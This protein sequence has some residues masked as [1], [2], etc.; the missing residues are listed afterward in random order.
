[1]GCGVGCGVGTDAKMLG[2]KMATESTVSEAPRRGRPGPT[3]R[4]GER[5]PRGTPHTPTPHAHTHA[6]AE[7]RTAPGPHPTRGTPTRRPEGT[8]KAEA[9]R[10][11][12]RSRTQR[13]RTRN[14]ASRG[15]KPERDLKGTRNPEPNR[16]PS[17]PN[18]AKGRA[19]NPLQGQPQTSPKA[20]QEGP[21]PDG[22]LTGSR[23]RKG[24]SG[25]P[26]AKPNPRPG[27]PNPTEK[28]TSLPPLQ[29]HPNPHGRPTRSPKAHPGGPDLKDLEGPPKPKLKTEKRT[30][31]QAELKPRRNP[32]PQAGKPTG[33]PK[34]KPK[35]TQRPKTK[36]NS[37]TSEVRPKPEPRKPNAE[38]PNPKQTQGPK[39]YL[40]GAAA[41]TTGPGSRSRVHRGRDHGD[42]EK[43]QGANT[44][45]AS[46]ARGPRPEPPKR[47]GAVP[48]RKS[49]E[50][51]ERVEGRSRKRLNEAELD[52]P[53]PK[54]KPK[55][56]PNPPP[57]KPKTRPPTRRHASTTGPKKEDE[58]DP[59]SGEPVKGGAASRA[60][61]PG[62]YPPQ[63]H[64]KR[65]GPLR[66]RKPVGD[67]RQR[68]KSPEGR[69]ET[70]PKPQIKVQ[71]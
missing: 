21:N 16:R 69:G 32:N 42:E 30:E 57:R 17:R 51:R 5:A 47:R 2:P 7:E 41:P 12:G 63:G 39:R 22:D 37:G 28:P 11:G 19:Y 45:P 40:G 58:A 60:P 10:R 34:P 68:T 61:E 1:M 36:T 38:N 50:I 15:S 24:T 35:P 67:G 48:G 64:L 46:T 25:A 44:V 43:G 54:P 56:K 13:G 55:P 9:T 29:G 70:D 26:E 52:A 33:N 20:T 8:R 62:G 6:K 27:R 49:Q 18:P 23:N 3:G 65:E 59:P 71:G 53:K 14:E 31:G 66:L 4:E